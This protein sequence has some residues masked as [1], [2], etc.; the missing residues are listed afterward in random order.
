[1]QPR[2]QRTQAD[3]KDMSAH[4]KASKIGKV[5]A[6]AKVAGCDKRNRGPANARNLSLSGRE[7]AN[8]KGPPLDRPTVSRVDEGRSSSHH[9]RQEQEWQGQGMWSIVLSVVE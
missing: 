4:R 6:K 5:Y 2:L 8:R 7:R 9:H 3:G 1:M